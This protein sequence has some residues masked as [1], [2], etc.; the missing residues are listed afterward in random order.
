[1]LGKTSEFHRIIRPCCLDVSIALAL[2][3][4]LDFQRHLPVGLVRCGLHSSLER[5]VLD[6]LHI[7]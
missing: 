3:L 7:T 5:Q 1:M 2:A 4:V 6:C